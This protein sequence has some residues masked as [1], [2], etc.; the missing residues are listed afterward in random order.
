V[1]IAISNGHA[2]ATVLSAIWSPADQQLVA[3]LMA[4]TDKT[5][6]TALKAE[7]EK[8]NRNSCVSLTGD[9]KAELAGARRGYIQLST[10][11]E[12]AN[13]Q[14]HVMALLHWRAHDPRTVVASKPTAHDAENSTVES[15]YF[16]VVSRQGDCLPTL[17]VERLQLGLS[18]A[19]KPEW[20]ET[21]LQ[22]GREAELVD[23]LPVGVAMEQKGPLASRQVADRPSVLPMAAGGFQAALR[24]T[25][26]EDRWGDLIG[27][28]LAVGSIEL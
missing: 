22:L 3:V 24:V 14:G 21:L 15:D 8:N 23:C 27:S 2:R 1:S 12:K 18:W 26:D 10:S 9:V 4:A 19:L 17:F 6:L 5:V 16:Y 11:L 20:A 25:K 28:A 7:L 13:A